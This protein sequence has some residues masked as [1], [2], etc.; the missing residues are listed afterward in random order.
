M[1][2][3]LG[4]FTTEGINSK[5]A[6]LKLAEVRKVAQKFGKEVANSIPISPPCKPIYGTDTNIRL[7]MENYGNLLILVLP[8]SKV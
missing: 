1:R 5:E 4:I 2:L 3:I 7:R 6:K 8:F